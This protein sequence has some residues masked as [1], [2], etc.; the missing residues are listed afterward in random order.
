MIDQT[1][2]EKLEFNKV[3]NYLSNYA[4]TERGKLFLTSLIPSSDKEYI[5]REG[6]LVNEAKEIIIRSGNPP[7][8]YLS[9]LEKYLSESKVEGAIL[10][11]TKI[12][13]VLKLAKISR[14]LFQF[15]KKECN[16]DSYFNHVIQNL[17]IDKVF[18]HQIE[19]IV[20]EQG[21]VKE[22][23]SSTLAEIRREI[24]SKR[25]ELVK[26]INR[27]IKN[28]KDDDIV[29]EDYLTL[30]DGRMVIPIKSEH[31]RHIRGFIHSES[32]TGQTVYIEPE[33]TLDLNNDI[34]SLSFAENREVERLLKEV[35]RLIGEVSEKLKA[36]LIAITYIDSVF[37]RAKHSIEIIGAFPQIDDDKPLLFSDARHPIL[38][39]KLGRQNTVPLNFELTNDK[40]VVITGPNAGGKTVVL[41]T[42][43]ILNLMVQSGLHVPVNPDS[44][45]H[46]FKNILL[47]IGDQQ[48]IE[49]DLS[50]FSSHL[51][52]LNNIIEQADENSLVLLDEIGTGTD[53]TEGSA[54]AA[55]ILKKLLSKR[56][57][58]FASTHHGSLKIFA[59]NLDGMQNAAMQFDHTNLSPTYVFKLG[60]PGSSYAFEIA[61]RTGLSEEILNEAANYID[62]DKHNVE[63]FLSELEEKSHKLSIKLKEME[64]ENTRLQGLSNVYK[65]SLDKLESEKKAILKKVKS[66]AEDYLGGINKKIEKVIKDLRESNA[67]KD[68][69]KSARN[70][71]QE[72]KTE[73]KE[74]ITDEI[75][76]IDDNSDF[77][78]GDFVGINKSQ[79]V[80]KIIDI[81]KSK[82]KA[83]ILAGAIKM[84]VKLDEIFHS[85]EK[86]D[87]TSKKDYSSFKIPNANYRIDL[88]GE[89]PEEAEFEIIKFLD[90]AHQAGLERVEIL[91][92]K[93]TG[94]LK[95]TVWDI[96]KADDRIKLFNFAPIEYGGEGITIVEFK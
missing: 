12:V 31:K 32:S 64:I 1:V 57:T 7:I 92:G 49:D 42:I 61:R 89:K 39:K 75:E 18:E 91:H 11:S 21:E 73:N 60:I 94:A 83:T 67:S 52:N 63:K 66:D 69:I 93:G 95:K 6:T 88:R 87:E 37:A 53:P 41:K 29:R 30:R 51:K 2:I 54:L 62:T 9:D 36:S 20:N 78:V 96:L 13:E 34:I 65:N 25:N 15:I 17:F 43:G 4:A 23:A 16:P 86:K 22:N 46:I 82:N 70:I 28:L 58:V 77:V 84:Q 81:N 71:I 3:L 74:F 24:I 8:D 59:Y 72:I 90:E 85:K 47:D 33:E 68:V 80:G 44:N 14:L 40:V 10:S 27:I 56:A 55:A 48:S 19:K 79:T 76:K 50:T 38:I 45:F 5:I 35:T 26:S